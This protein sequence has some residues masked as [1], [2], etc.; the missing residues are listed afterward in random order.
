MTIEIQ[1]AVYS[2]LSVSTP[3][4]IIVDAAT[5]NDSYT[6]AQVT[7]DPSTYKWAT[8]LRAS[9]G[10]TDQSSAN[11]SEAAQAGDIVQVNAGTYSV[12]GV[13]VW[14]TTQSG[15]TAVYHPANS[16][17]AG[18]WIEFRANGTVTLQLTGY[19][20]PLLGS[21]N[22][23]YIRFRGFTIDAANCVFADAGT[24][25]CCLDNGV[26]NIE[27]LE[28]TIN[29]TQEQ[30]GL[31]GGNQAGF[32]LRN[33]DN[34][35]IKN[36]NV[37]NMRDSDSPAGH[38]VGGVM[39]YNATNVTIEH[40][41]FVSNGMGVYIKGEVV[42]LPQQEGI[43]IRYNR[44]H[45]CYK[46]I[47][48]GD[49]QGSGGGNMAYQN[50]IYEGSSDGSGDQPAIELSDTAENW[51]I[52]NNTIDTYEMAFGTLSN[53]APAGTTIQNNIA[54]NI[55]PIASGE[56][57]NAGNITSL[58][59]ATID[60]NNYYNYS[61]NVGSLNSTSYSTLANWRTGT[62]EEANTTEVDPFYEDAANDDY[63]LGT[64]STLKSGQANDGVDVAN[65]LGGGTSAPI[66]KGCYINAGQTET[67]G[68][69]S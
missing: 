13:N 3:A 34:V 65:L 23:D 10:S 56:L 40:N 1:R 58:S 28:N 29:G 24:G 14:G 4:T 39:T 5:G 32:F 33:A 51:M 61:G 57:F 18:N 43:I 69:E 12:A 26:A 20:R 63:R 25:Y 67:I 2:A 50:L 49:S 30:Y 8:I 47:C 54:S 21:Y 53:Y 7:S 64:S 36:N 11:A 52:V 16:G 35:L 60:Y 42:S 68:I 37:N 9:N 48:L 38:N 59:G 41:D 44:I 31:A 27:F 66:N 19:G 15:H 62:G 17:T 46:G 6:Y 22:S 45:Q 55:T